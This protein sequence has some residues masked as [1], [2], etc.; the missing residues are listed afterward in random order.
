MT[1]YTYQRGET[2]SLAL[3]AVDGDPLTVSAISARLKAIPPG[4]SSV[5]ADAPVAATFV[6]LP[7]TAT[8]SFPAGWTLT[9]S[10]ATSLTLAPGSYLADARMEI[11]A[12]V[13]ITDQIALKLREPVT[14]S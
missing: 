6:V 14:P 8:P 12:G 4:R 1:P 10:A 11:A 7:R 13:V 9:I 2:I 5:P 3:D